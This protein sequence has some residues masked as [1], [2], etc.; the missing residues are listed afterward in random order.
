MFEQN[1][2]VEVCQD[3]SV[4]KHTYR[5]QVNHTMGP[6]VVKD[7]TIQAGSKAHAAF[8]VGMDLLSELLLE[9]GVD[10]ASMHNI[11]DHF[12]VDVELVG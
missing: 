6:P 5:V 9:G 7:V 4:T 1:T 10:E 8:L 11:M 3:A 2:S 12:V